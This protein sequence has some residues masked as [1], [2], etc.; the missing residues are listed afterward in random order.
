MEKLEKVLGEYLVKKAP[1]LPKNIKEVVIKFAPWV[2]MLMMVMSV[3]AI[4]AILGTGYG[5][6][7]GVNY[8][9]YWVSIGVLV[10][11]L[12][13]EGLALKGL[14][15][16][17]KSGWRMMF[18]AT[19]VSAV[20]NVLVGSWVGLIVGTLISLYVLFQVREYYK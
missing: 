14:L 4:L 11:T 13:L 5:Y 19:L 18:Y 3:P 12:I 15:D 6:G 17:T 1:A 16:K 7:Y 9:M 20:H 10:V 8:G 2:V